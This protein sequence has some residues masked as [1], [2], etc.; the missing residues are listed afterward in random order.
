MIQLG[1]TE[2]PMHKARAIMVFPSLESSFK[3]L[4][5]G[6]LAGTIRQDR[7]SGIFGIIGE[8]P[9]MIPLK[10]Q[11]AGSRGVK[12]E[13]KYELARDSFLTGPTG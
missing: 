4:E 7:G 11:L 1:F 10:I 8:M 9:R 2:L 5:T 6:A 3:I 12:K 13:F